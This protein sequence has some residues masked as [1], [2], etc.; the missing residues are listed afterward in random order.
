MEADAG[1]SPV[2]TPARIQ[3]PNEASPLN[4]FGSPLPGETVLV[5]SAQA[6]AGRQLSILMSLLFVIGFHGALIAI[7]ILNWSLPCERPLAAYLLFAGIFGVFGGFLFF[8]L[9]L[10]RARMEASLLPTEIWKPSIAPIDR[11][12]VIA[13]VSAATLTALIGTLF[14]RSATTC[15]YTSPIVHNW[16]LATLLLYGA[17]G[18]L[19]GLVPVL[20]A[21]LPLFA[22][23]ILPL[24]ALLVAFANWLSEAGKRGA[25]SALTLLRRWLDLSGQGEDADAQPGL[26]PPSGATPT[27]TFALYVNTAALVWLFGYMLLEASHSFRLPCDAPL[28]TFV[29]GAAGVGLAL[30]LG[31]FISEVF[32][33]PLPPVTKVEHARAREDRKR[34]VYA[35]GYLLAAIFLWGALGMLW[36][37]DSES[38]ARTSPSIYRLALLLELVYVLMLG[39]AMLVAAVLG[40]DFCLSGKLRVAVILEE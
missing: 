7:A 29:V 16:A 1:M 38:C 25:F 12:F 18:L 4:G 32:R 9:E 23:A 13:T 8:S 40:V 17:F 22:A 36:I 2:P 15:S 35:L 37:K 39:V 24:I 20:S 11:M 33:D 19:V 5:L 30:A 6:R 27:S 26:Q 3:P 14:Y 34:K 28:P 10:K 31:S 21:L